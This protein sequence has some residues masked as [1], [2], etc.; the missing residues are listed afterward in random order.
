MDAEAALLK[1]DVAF[2][3]ALMCFVVGWLCRYA[4]AATGNRQLASI[5]RIV[6]I[7]VVVTVMAQALWEVISAIAAWFKGWETRVP[8]LFKF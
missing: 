2:V 7:L 1:L 3:Q 6:T 4:A 8:W 5:L